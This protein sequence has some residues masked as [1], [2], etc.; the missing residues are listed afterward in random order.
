M[1]FMLLSLAKIPV[2]KSKLFNV[3]ESFLCIQSTGLLFYDLKLILLIL[4]K[5]SSQTD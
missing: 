3:Q 4:A 1:E 5:M 2:F